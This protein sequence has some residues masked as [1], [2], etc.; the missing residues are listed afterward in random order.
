MAK[1]RIR[2]E[3]LEDGC[4]FDEDF[5]TV[6][7]CE[8]FCMILDK[9]DN[10]AEVIHGMTF[11]QLAENIAVCDNVLPAAG[12]ARAIVEAKASLRKYKVSNVLDHIFGGDRE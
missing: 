8:G 12:I 7:E 4:Q 2:V 5:Q 1:Y 10:A 6:M 9:G 3:A 11:M